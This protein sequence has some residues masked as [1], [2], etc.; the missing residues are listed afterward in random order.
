MPLDPARAGIKQ[1]ILNYN[2]LNSKDLSK[3]LFLFLTDANINLIYFF[4]NS[5][6]RVFLLRKIFAPII[7]FFEIFIFSLITELL[8]IKQLSSTF[9]PLF[10]IAPGATWRLF[11]IITSCSIIEPVFIIQ[12]SPILTFELIMTPCITIVPFPIKLFFE[13]IV[14]FETK[15]GN[16]Y[17]NDNK[18]LKIFF[19]KFIF[20]ICPKA[21]NA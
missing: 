12:L 20:F 8:P 1:S 14:F 2:I 10:K 16:L 9:V 17:P 6:I 21:T 13:I 4:I 18:F 5:L 15:V 7:E 19:L 3:T 11:P